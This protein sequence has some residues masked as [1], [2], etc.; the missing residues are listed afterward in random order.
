[1]ALSCNKIL[2]ALLH[3]KTSNN[4]G[5]FYCLNCPQSFRTENFSGIVMPKEPRRNIRI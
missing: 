5:D 2:S 3:R 4:Q 1:M